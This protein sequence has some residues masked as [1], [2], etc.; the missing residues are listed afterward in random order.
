MWTEELG[1]LVFDSGPELVQAAAMAARSSDHLGRRG[2]REAEASGRGDGGEEEGGVEEGDGRRP[3]GYRE[4]H[5]GFREDH[6]L[7]APREPPPDGSA[8]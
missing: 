6:P 1:D 7:G 4:R 3:R 5:G 8:L 2:D